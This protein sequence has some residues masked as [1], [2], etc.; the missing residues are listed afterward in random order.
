M[1]CSFSSRTTVV[2]WWLLAGRRRHASGRLLLS[3]SGRP[4]LA[5][6]STIADQK[7]SLHLAGV[8]NLRYY[9]GPYSVRCWSDKVSGEMLNI[10]FRTL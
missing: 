5:F 4:L 6:A 9:R 2:C 10:E 8:E 7:S 1:V 3:T